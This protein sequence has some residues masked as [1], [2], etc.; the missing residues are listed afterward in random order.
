VDIGAAELTLQWVVSSAADSG[1]GSLRQAM[2][3]VDSNA[4]ITFAAGLSGET[5]LLTNGQLVPVNSLTLDGSAL[6]NEIQING[7]ASTRIFNVPS[8]M[9]VALNSLTITNGHDGGNDG[10]GGIYNDGVL[11]LSHVTV[12]GNSASYGGGIYNNGTLLVSDSTI[13]HNLATT[14]G[15]GIYNEDTLAV[16]NSTVS[17]NVAQDGGGI[18]NDDGPGMIT[19]SSVTGN[20]SAHY[21]GGIY[22]YDQLTVQNSTLSA[23]VSTNVG[24]GIYNSWPLTLIH[25]TLSGNSANQGGGLYNIYNNE[26]VNVTNSIIAGNSAP[27]ASDVFNNGNFRGAN[28]LT[29]GN[30]L[31]APLGNYGGPTQTMPPLPGSP[32]LDAA[33]SLGL[34]LDQRGFPRPS[35]PASDIGAVESQYTSRHVQV[36][37]NGLGTNI[38]IT[39]TFPG[40]F[41]TNFL[42]DASGALE[43]VLPLDPHVP[44][45]LT[46]TPSVPGRPGLGFSPPTITNSATQASLSV[47]PFNPF[48]A[49]YNGLFYDADG[50][51]PA[52]SGFFTLTLT[53]SGSFS[54]T[55]QRGGKRSSFTGAFDRFGGAPPVTTRGT[56]GSFTVS[57]WVD[58]TAN[59]E[60]LIG[61][62]TDGHWLAELSADRAV[63]DARTNHSPYAAKYTLVIPGTNGVSALPGGDGYATLTVDAGGKVKVAGS[64]ADGTAISQSVPLSKS[65]ELPL[66][67]SL[68]AGKGAAL[69]WLL[70]SNTPLSD[71]RGQV[72]WLKP[73]LPTGK[74]YR[75]GFAYETMAEGSKYVGGRPVLGLGTASVAFAGGNLAGPFTNHVTIG[76]NNKVASTDH[77]TLR[78]TP[79]TGLFNGSV[80]PAAGKNTTFKGVV[81]QKQKTARGYFLGTD[82]SG[83]VLVG[84]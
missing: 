12:T 55:L 57:L 22:N 51:A 16:N 81:L 6:P 53:P 29:N 27:T 77:L 20:L 3:Q 66:Y 74:V 10:G 70:I 80:T 62:V 60:R 45:V 54:A 75:S 46:L 23:N 35:G 69:G 63:F 11:A 40:G 83:Q 52:S 48:K 67:A 14:D 32:A 39:V 43:A 28:N 65:G 56:A 58:M 47:V 38:L 9:N 61:T 50:V 42:T 44:G 7:N 8:G 73:S 37:L 84:P 25:V 33:G 21:G 24:G 41:T 18:Y 76:S 15:G 64:L 72:L 31:L 82:K 17:G 78:F 5:I 71:V 13:R 59:A 19:N 2:S 4:M 68:Y 36:A 34:A 1:S 26:M 79:A 30:P 49:G